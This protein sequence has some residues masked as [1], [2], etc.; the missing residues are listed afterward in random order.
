MASQHQQQQPHSTT[1]QHSCKGFFVWE[2]SSQPEVFDGTCYGV[3][4][5]LRNSYVDLLE[6]AST[7]P[8]PGGVPNTTVASL[9][10]LG[11]A[12]Y[13]HSVDPNTVGDGSYGCLLHVL[14]GLQARCG[15]K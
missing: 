13:Q 2:A 4:T 1:P 14:L 12:A 15:S 8:Q 6:H 11:S 5:P 10:C 3:T 7:R 9:A